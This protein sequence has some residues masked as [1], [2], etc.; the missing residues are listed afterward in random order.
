M[1]KIYALVV[2]TF[3]CATKLL[4]QI[5]ELQGR[6]YDQTTKEGI[7]FANVVLEQNG[8]Q[9]GYGQTDDDGNY[10]IKPITPG[11][12]DV[13]CSY[14]GYRPKTY[15][16]VVITADRITFQ[17]LP[18][19]ASVNQ[20]P[21]V[22]VSTQKLIEPDK[23]TTGS[24]LTKDEIDHLAT[25]D[26]RNYASLTAGVFQRDDGDN[27]N[28]GGARDYA[29]KYYVDGIPMRGSLVLPASAIEQLTVLTGGIPARYG[30]AT[31]GI[32]NI[33]TRGPSEKFA[34]GAELVTSEFLDGF[35]YNLA[36]VNFS[37]P[38]YTQYKGTDSAI[39]KIGF[40][41]YSRI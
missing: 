30:D 16:S 39:S 9:K 20:L 6:A 8:L 4:A 31:G 7:P 41:C 12:Y 13:K 1:K 11:T 38:I 22:V 18:M 15:T 33:T 24:T 23:T 37:G 36:N 17:D 5:G 14:L 34:G 2:L 40:F 29:N 3:L 35:G 21:D 27:L 32:I 26:T 28:I 25:R 19:E 10:T